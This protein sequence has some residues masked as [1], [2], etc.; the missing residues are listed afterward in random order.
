[1]NLMEAYKRF[2]VNGNGFPK[3]KSKHDNKASCR[4][5]S[6]SISKRNNYL[7]NKITLTNNLKDVKFACSDEYTKYL[8]KHKEGIKSATLSKTKSGKYFLSILSD[9]DICKTWSIIDCRDDT[10]GMLFD[11]SILDPTKAQKVED[12]RLSKLNFRRETGECD[13]N[14]IQKV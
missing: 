1:M 10:C 6:E 14:G 12:L 3:F 4:F 9:G 5:P 8:N 7:D 11:S 13:N 2:F